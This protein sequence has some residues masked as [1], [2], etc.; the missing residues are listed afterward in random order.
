VLDGAVDLKV[1]TAYGHHSRA[2][3]KTAH[4]PNDAVTKI[5]SSD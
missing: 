5:K 2:T 1:A 4:I 3:A